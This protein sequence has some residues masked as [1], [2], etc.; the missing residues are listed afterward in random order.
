MNNT[1]TRRRHPQTHEEGAVV[2]RI[3]EQAKKIPS[4]W[5]LWAALGSIGLSLGLR[6]LD[7]KEDS[8]FVGSWVPTL[9]ILGLYNKLSK[10]G[11][12]DIEGR[13]AY[14]G[15]VGRMMGPEGAE[16]AP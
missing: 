15:R 3:E 13:A 14:G 10:P 8:D 11:P 4:D 6:R 9:L 5:F 2:R 12:S 7:R 1:Q 16:E